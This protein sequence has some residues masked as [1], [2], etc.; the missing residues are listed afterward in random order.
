MRP[1]ITLDETQSA[2]HLSRAEVHNHSHATGYA[3]SITM[4]DCTEG[5]VLFDT[6]LVQNTAEWQTTC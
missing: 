2:I 4:R 6:V 1:A 3:D 5:E